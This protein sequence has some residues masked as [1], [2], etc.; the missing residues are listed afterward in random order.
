MMLIL[1]Y[2]DLLLKINYDNNFIAN[3]IIKKKEYLNKYK[4]ISY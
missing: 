4:Y 3:T 1:E 2:I